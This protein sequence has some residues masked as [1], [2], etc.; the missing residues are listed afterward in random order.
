MS[1]GL[2]VLLLAGLLAGS[3]PLPV[4]AQPSR[5]AGA[6]QAPRSA[7]LLQRPAPFEHFAA[8]EFLRLR[9]S[10]DRPP[11]LGQ[12]VKLRLRCEVRDIE[13]LPVTV[14]LQVPR[15]VE[16]SGALPRPG[17][18]VEPG[19]PLEAELR[20][21]VRHEVARG[22]LQLQAEA[23]FPLT[24]AKSYF[25]SRIPLF[26]P[27]ARQEYARFV[28]R[29]PGRLATH[30]TIAFRTSAAEA[31]LGTTAPVALHA[32]PSELSFALLP[33]SCEA[34]P[35]CKLGWRALVKALGEGQLPGPEGWCRLHA[36]ALAKLREGRPGVAAAVLRELVAKLYR[37]PGFAE[38]RPALMSNL[39]VA[40]ALEGRVPE[41]LMTWRGVP[42]REHN[43]HVAFNEATCLQR[44]PNPQA[45]V[46]AL[47]AYRK[48][49]ALSPGYTLARKRL[50]TL[51]AS[52]LR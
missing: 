16:L 7:H 41:A 43:A 17:T 52:G 44:Q 29:P 8:P 46:H 49:L 34:M 27:K 24:A 31:T 9:A 37:A 11:E 33:V 12:P 1:R 23:P 47:E 40:L 39:A 50:E 25:L 5:T 10:L 51:E 48:A 28:A 2:A 4:R 14:T 21:V 20:L 26:S 45:R 38:H 42:G 35:P 30:Q 36:M 22:R 18:R 32:V 15:G 6:A 13:A 19:K 3:P